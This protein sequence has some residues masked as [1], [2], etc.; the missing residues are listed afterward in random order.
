MS[1]LHYSEI[2][3][4]IKNNRIWLGFGFNL[5]MVYKTPYENTNEANQKFVRSKGLDPDDNYIKVPAITWYTNL[6]HR[7]RHEHLISYKAYTPE[8][9]PTYDNFDA[10]DVNEV[11]SIPNEYM[12]VM[13]V[14]DTFLGQYNPEE[15]ELIGIGS[16]KLASSIG[17]R[18][19]YRGRTDLAYTENGKHKCPYS[20]ILI[21]RRQ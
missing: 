21:R 18:K 8:E 12:G 6:D 10:I 14:P 1:A 19:N 13:G 9:Y 4:F 20:R 17:V 5:S 11:A 7:K 15:F 2:F 3:P 16:G